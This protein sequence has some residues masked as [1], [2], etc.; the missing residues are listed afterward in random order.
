LLSEPI[1]PVFHERREKM[2]HMQAFTTI[3][4]GDVWHAS[5][6]MHPER[7]GKQG[8]LWPVKAW[9]DFVNQDLVGS[10]IGYKY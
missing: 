6:E 8:W 1:N 7:Y 5:P 10:F 2:E 9:N 3:M 4:G